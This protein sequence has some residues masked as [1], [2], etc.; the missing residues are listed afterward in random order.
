MNHNLVTQDPL[1]YDVTTW[2]SWTVSLNSSDW[3]VWLP[4]WLTVIWP[5]SDMWPRSSEA[6]ALEPSDIRMICI[7]N[8]T[9]RSRRG[10]TLFSCQAHLVRGSNLRSLAVKPYC[11]FFDSTLVWPATGPTLPCRQDVTSYYCVPDSTTRRR[12]AVL[13]DSNIRIRRR[14]WR[15]LSGLCCNS[16]S[17]YC[18][19]TY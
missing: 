7:S 17:W 18:T 10:L 11:S 12:Y 2:L 15:H 4:D 14:R 19:F 5:T 3:T 9:S 1:G 8:E 13:R 16:N 6:L